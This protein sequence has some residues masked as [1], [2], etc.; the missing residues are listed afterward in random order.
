MNEY[1]L[2]CK[3]SKKYKEYQKI[4]KKN[5]MRCSIS[6]KGDCYDNACAETLFHSFKVEWVYGN[7]YHTREACNHSV[8][9]YIEV[10]ITRRGF[11]LI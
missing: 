9:E 11:I 4:L 1:G 10:F 7:V 3:A 5:K 8:I 2:V 6:K